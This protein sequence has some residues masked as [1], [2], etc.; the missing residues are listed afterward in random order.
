M[1]RSE[2]SER[3]AFH[4]LVTAHEVPYA[5]KSVLSQKEVAMPWV[6]RPPPTQ[7]RRREMDQ[8][9]AFGMYQKAAHDAEV[10]QREREERKA[11]IP[12]VRAERWH[13][14]KRKTDERPLE[15]RDVEICRNARGK[16][17]RLLTP[18]E[19]AAHFNLKVA[20]DIPDPSHVIEGR[21]T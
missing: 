21:E 8:E 11:A 15:F 3:F 13:N 17:S 19:L 5:R 1:Q 9:H 4:P 12:H 16:F 18:A 10:A 2:Q 7:T 14:R 6:P 20:R